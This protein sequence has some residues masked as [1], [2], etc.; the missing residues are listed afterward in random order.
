LLRPLER[1]GFKRPIILLRLEGIIKRLSR[2]KVLAFYLLL[3]LVVASVILT[4]AVIARLP[5]ASPEV[6][7]LTDV[8]KKELDIFTEMNKL[9]T[10]LATLTIGATSAFMINRDSRAELRPGTLGRAITGW[11]FTGASLYFGHLSY[12]RVL[13]ML[14]GHF[15]DL[16]LGT[17]WWPSRAQFWSFLVGVV[18]LLDFVRS[19]ITRARSTLEP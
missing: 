1:S 9:L 4:E 5:F 19:S 18:V 8:E 12:Q 15:F 7:N 13:W 17:V 10:T 3:A 16:F 6:T 11:V 2:S 14:N